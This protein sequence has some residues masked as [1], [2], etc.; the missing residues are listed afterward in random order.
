VF[1]VGTAAIDQRLLAIFARPKLRYTTKRVFF[2]YGGSVPE[3]FGG[4]L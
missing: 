3:A 1:I 2:L 4:V